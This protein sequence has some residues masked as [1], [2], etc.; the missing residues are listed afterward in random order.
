M[1]VFLTAAAA[2]AAAGA[3]AGGGEAPGDGASVDSGGATSG[4]S[5][6]GGATSAGGAA[7][8][9]GGGGGGVAAAGGSAGTG[10]E[11]PTRYT[12]STLRSPV[13]ETVATRLRD[14]AT[15]EPGRSDNV[16][17]KVGASGTVSQHFMTCLAGSAQP[18]YTLD[19]DGRD[20]LLPSVNWFRTGEAD[21]S[22]PFDRETLA[23]KIGRSATWAISGSPSPL[24]TEIDAIDPRFALVNYGTNDMQLGTTHA[25]AL[26]PFYENLSALL[27]ELE[28]GGIVPIVTGLNPRAD[29]TDATAW[30]P[31][32]NAVTLGV[33][34]ARQLPFINLYRAVNDLADHGLVGD[35]VHGNA[36]SSGGS[37]PCVFTPGGLEFNY[38]VR[39]LLTMQVLDLVK[40]A[41]VDEV[42]M[43]AQE[44]SARIAGAGT[45]EDPF[46][47]DQLPFT[48]W[49]DTSESE[50]RLID[51]YSGCAADQDESGPEYFYALAP[52]PTHGDAAAVAR[53]DLRSRLRRHRSALALRWHRWHRW[54]PRR[55]LHGPARPHVARRR[56]RDGRPAGSRHLCDGQRRGGWTGALRR[57]R[58][59]GGGSELL[60]ETQPLGRLA[61]TGAA[62]L[63]ASSCPAG[64]LDDTVSD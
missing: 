22:T 27:D 48:H 12:E 59:R 50:S 18:G 32:Y 5:G 43:D 38:N 34:E 10:T 4:G 20:D 63:R 55:K 21:G 31:T 33:A 24:E 15:A 8:A 30:V 64:F 14:I 42:A 23:A 13:T 51:T 17:M 36:Y 56:R 57:C 7:G 41:V 58:L 26:W 52:P 1:S 44:G 9:A 60:S 2:L 49:I 54:R 28:D 11:G 53:N 39:N 45:I 25:S 16:F 40:L 61:I 47:I 19:L 6:G 37:Q 46:V 62:D 3:C 35:G 29:L